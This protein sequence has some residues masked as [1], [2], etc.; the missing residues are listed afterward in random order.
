MFKCSKRYL[1][2]PNMAPKISRI[3]CRKNEILNLRDKSYTKLE[4]LQVMID[5]S[6]KDI[7]NYT[8]YERISGYI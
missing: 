1:L 7:V 3:F 4:L 8:G 5:L 6:V 2:L